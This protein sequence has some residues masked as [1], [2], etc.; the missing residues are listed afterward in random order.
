MHAQAIL[1]AAS[2]LAPTPDPRLNQDLSAQLSAIVH[3]VLQPYATG[4]PAGTSDAAQKAVN[5]LKDEHLLG[6]ARPAVPS[7]N[8]VEQY[9]RPLALGTRAANFAGDIAQI[10]NAFLRGDIEGAREAIRTLAKH[11]GRSEPDDATLSKTVDQLKQI[12]GAVE[13]PIEHT[14]IEQPDRSIDITWDKPTGKVKI[15]VLDRKG[16]NGK[17]VRTTFSGDTAAQAD[18]TGKSL[19]VTGKLV[20]EK[21]QETT[22]EQGKNVRDKINGEWVDQ[23]GNT[24]L[25]SGADASLTATKVQ[26]GHQIPYQGKFELGKVTGQHIVN[27]PADVTDL[28][29]GVKAELAAK[30][31][32]PYKIV[33][34]AN[35]T[36][37]KLEGTW[38]SLHVTYSGM[39]QSVESVQDPYDVPLVLTRKSNAIRILLT[40]RDFKPLDEVPVY[41][42]P[43][44]GSGGG[45]VWVEVQVPREDKDFDDG[46]VD[47]ITIHLKSDSDPAGV[48]VVCVETSPSSRIFR[49]KEAV[50][51]YPIAEEVTP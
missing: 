3:D 11:A 30:Y 16:P 1:A 17:P 12:E 22:Q 28:P 35:D 18:S 51:L 40:D 2:L 26:S 25:L 44:D 15:D 46:K 47:S 37:D 50:N 38:I 5:I 48:D 36:G 27:D 34:N 19:E 10:H 6:S 23:D 42:M 32:P 33:L 39:D 21:P 8:L 45:E 13:K 9:A 29:D 4:M 14:T 49:S 41:V 7:N 20:G 31:H 24:W 43:R